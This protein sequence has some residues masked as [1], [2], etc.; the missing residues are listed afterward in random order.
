MLGKINFKNILEV[1]KK[2]YSGLYEIQNVSV[3]IC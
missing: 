1:Q 2:L 3:I